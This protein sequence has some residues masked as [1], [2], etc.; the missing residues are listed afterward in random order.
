[1][2]VKVEAEVSGLDLN[3]EINFV[4]RE[5]T[6]VQ[7]QNMHYYV[8]VTILDL[9]YEKSFAQ[10]CA[11]LKEPTRFTVSLAPLKCIYGMLSVT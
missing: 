5:Y 7:L 1:M 3:T 11:M 9:K 2:L 8:S 4:I 10:T 6:L